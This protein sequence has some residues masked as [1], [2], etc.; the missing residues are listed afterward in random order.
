MGGRTDAKENDLK[1]SEEYMRGNYFV[2]PN[3]L[4][5]LEL[6]AKSIAVYAYLMRLENKKNHICWAKQKTIGNA[7]GIKSN[8][9]VAKALSELEDKELIYRE[10]MSM[11][12]NGKKVNGIQKF[13]I[14]PIN[15]AVQHKQWRQF[16]NMGSAADEKKLLTQIENYNARHPD[17]PVRFTAS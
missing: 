1:T 13:T 5:S 15:D 2:L 11:D 6:S 3:E 12:H 10:N 8:K 16:E 4:F 14:R 7:V 9:T 17:D